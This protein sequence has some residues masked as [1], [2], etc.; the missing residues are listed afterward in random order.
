M[1]EDLATRGGGVVGHGVDLCE[2]RRIAGMVERHGERFLDRVFTAGE[3]EYARSGGVLRVERLAAR[4]AAKE[5]V[6]KALGTGWRGGIAWTDVEVCRDASG[7]PR[8]RLAG[9]AAAEAARQGIE[10]WHLSL[11][12]ASGL[13]I[14]SVL[15]CG[16][17]AVGDS[18]SP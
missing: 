17:G 15:A 16:G 10:S 9:E 4:F 1:I 14:A 5:A 2:E 8:V 18:M 13:A 7:R 3:Q 6:L 11:T 12:H